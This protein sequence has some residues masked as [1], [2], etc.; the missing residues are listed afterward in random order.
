MQIDDRRTLAEIILA[1][2][3]IL[4]VTWPL[5]PLRCNVWRAHCLGLRSMT[6]VVV[7]MIYAGTVLLG[8]GKG[9]WAYA[10]PRD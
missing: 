3:P 6:F 4:I 10:F 7:S 5:L 9:E 8:M 1:P 2:D